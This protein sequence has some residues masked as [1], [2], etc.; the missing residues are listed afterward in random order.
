M[1]TGNRKRLLE[2][3]DIAKELGRNCCLA[4]PSLHAFTGNDYTSAFHGLGKVKAYKLM[5][6]SEEFQHA[7]QKLGDSFTFD[8]SL[9]AALEK[10]VCQLYGL[11]C[12]NTND[13][14][15]L[16]FISKN[17]SPEL[18][19][20]VQNALIKKSRPTCRTRK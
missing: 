9:F 1:Y 11:K 8:A 3:T 2:I 20:P 16:K 19:V 7:F 15:Y 12:E 18:N 10:F 6:S 17:K 4:L 5:R 14:R 13:A